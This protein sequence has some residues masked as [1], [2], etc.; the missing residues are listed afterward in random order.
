MTEKS[1][2]GVSSEEHDGVSVPLEE[3]FNFFFDWA[4]QQV[5]QSKSLQQEGRVFEA[6]VLKGE[7]VGSAK[8][9][10]DYCASKLKN[11]GDGDDVQ[12]TVSGFDWQQFLRKRASKCAN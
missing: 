7:A 6:M 1:N 10:R 2:A 9:M 8:A 4:Q 11:L 5:E 3:V 12:L